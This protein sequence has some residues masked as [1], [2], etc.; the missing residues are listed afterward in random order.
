MRWLT[1]HSTQVFIIY[2]IALGLL[3]ITLLS[4]GVLS[5]TK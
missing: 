3:L 4:T 2:R 5:A 1:K